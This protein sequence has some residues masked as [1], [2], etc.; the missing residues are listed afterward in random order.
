MFD[1]YLGALPCDAAETADRARVGRED[2]NHEE[3]I[4]GLIVDL[5]ATTQV[6]EA[7]S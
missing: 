6:E 4:T 5:L 7:A 2:R 3:A 1:D